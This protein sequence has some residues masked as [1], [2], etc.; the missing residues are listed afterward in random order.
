MRDKSIFAELTQHW[1][2][3]FHKDMEALN[4][5]HSTIVHCC[6]YSL[7]SYYAPQVLPPDVLTRISDYVPEVVEYTQKIM[8]NGYA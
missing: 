3:E 2:E 5:G 1:E 6:D 4:V 7:L 8:D